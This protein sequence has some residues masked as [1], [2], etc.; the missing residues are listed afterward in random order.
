MSV[1]GLLLVTGVAAITM[2]A[3]LLMRAGIERSGG[4]RPEGAAQVVFGFA[5]LLLNPLFTL[6][7]VGYF[8][9]ALVWFRVLATEQ[10]SLAYPLLVSLTF[11]LVTGGAV[12]IFHEPMSLRKALG[13]LTVV[14]GIAIAS[15]ESAMR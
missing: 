3:N 11:L 4:F 9:G 10:L 2:A 12:L 15:S 1:S 6:G 14:A 13:L 7:F 8:V 5:N